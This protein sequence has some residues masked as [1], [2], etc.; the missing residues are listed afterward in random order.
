MTEPQAGEPGFV[1]PGGITCEQCTGFLTDYFEGTLP[2]AQR[3]SFEKHTLGCPPCAA[4]LNNYRRV[5]EMAKMAGGGACP[6]ATAPAPPGLIDA[7]L[8]ARAHDHGLPGRGPGKP[9]SI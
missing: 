4:F 2:R 7:I 6:E 1:P 5:T 3:E 9:P 8:K